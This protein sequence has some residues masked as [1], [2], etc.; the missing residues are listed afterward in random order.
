MLW[1]ALQLPAWDLTPMRWHAISAEDHQ[2][3]RGFRREACDVQDDK[4][5]TFDPRKVSCSRFEKQTLGAEVGNGAL[6]LYA[7]RSLDRDITWPCQAHREAIVGLGCRLWQEP[8]G[9]ATLEG[10]AIT[11][12]VSV[13]GH[14]SMLR[15]NRTFS[16]CSSTPSEKLQ[17]RCMVRLCNTGYG[18][19]LQGT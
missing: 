11:Q 5:I 16:S 13:H 3:N 15:S 14:S 6:A 8:P 1:G 19:V 18:C 9:V 7:A 2:S 12:Q 10:T 4:N 17:L